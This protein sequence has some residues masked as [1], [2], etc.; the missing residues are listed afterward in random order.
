MESNV[1]WLV[2][3]WNNMRWNLGMWW[4]KVIDLC[5]C[6]FFV[7]EH[8]ARK[9][10]K[11]AMARFCCLSRCFDKLR[12]LSL[13]SSRLDPVIIHFK[14]WWKIVACLPLKLVDVW[15]RHRPCTGKYT[16]VKP[17]VLR[18]TTLDAAFK[19]QAA[20]STRVIGHPLGAVRAIIM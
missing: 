14:K 8:N 17:R 5:G 12:F 4:L 20:D 13:D 10:R 15:S 1:T 16:W 11:L 9:H 7:V 18:M 19:V 6:F 3:W 2:S